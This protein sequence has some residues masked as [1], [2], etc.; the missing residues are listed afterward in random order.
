M[1][2]TI[3][4]ST[5]ARSETTTPNPVLPLPLPAPLRELDEVLRA[6]RADCLLA[7]DEYLEEVRVPFGGE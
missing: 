1:N 2:V 3:D 7:P 6:I 4:S 5:Q